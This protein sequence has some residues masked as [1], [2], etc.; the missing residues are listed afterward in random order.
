MSSSKITYSKNDIEHNKLFVNNQDLNK[1]LD[2]IRKSNPHKIIRLAFC[3]S[4]KEELLKEELSPKDHID[5]LES[6]LLGFKCAALILG[7]ISM[8]LFIIMITGSK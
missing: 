2:I 6:Q 5:H 8:F 7:C 4:I 1:V 3:E